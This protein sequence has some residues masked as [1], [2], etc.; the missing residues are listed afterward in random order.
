[1]TFQE[2]RLNPAFRDA[3]AGCANGLVQSI[4]AR[5]MDKSRENPSAG[6]SAEF[7]LGEIRSMSNLIAELQTLATEPSPL[8]RPKAG[9]KPL[10]SMQAPKTDRE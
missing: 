10:N 3:F 9:L 5:L 1:M 8:V 2:L 4:A 7:R 6:E